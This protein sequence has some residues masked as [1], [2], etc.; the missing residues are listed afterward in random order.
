MQSYY[1]LSELM[2]DQIWG[3]FLPYLQI[4]LNTNMVMSEIYKSLNTLMIILDT[5]VTRKIRFKIAIIDSLDQ[6]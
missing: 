3:H 4:L 2:G 6:L 5:S 1:S